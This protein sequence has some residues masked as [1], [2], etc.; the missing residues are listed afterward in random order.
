M[1][2]N[3]GLRAELPVGGG[4]VRLRG[5]GSGRAG[6]GKR[7]KVGGFSR[8]ARRRLLE[9]LASLNRNALPFLPLFLTLTYPGEYSLNPADWKRDLDVFLKRLRRAYPDAA[10]VWKLE[11]QKRG[12]PHYHLLVFGVEQIPHSWLRQAWYEVVGS[13]DAR[14]LLAGTRVERV[15]SWRGVMSYAAKYLGK[16][17]TMAEWPDYVGRWWG[18]SGRGLLPILL[19]TQYLGRGAFYAFRRVMYHYL[20]RRGVNMRKRARA[21]VTVFLDAKV[22][23]DLLALFGEGD[24]A[25]P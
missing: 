13:G 12:A 2:N 17:E 8:A 5:S 20:K 22:G 10:A 21:G 6:G 11:P 16:V 25:S 24:Y 3:G 19:Y 7:G 23:F 18:V 15:K 1:A 14:H 4:L 9:L